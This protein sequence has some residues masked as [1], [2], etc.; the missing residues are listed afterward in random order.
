[1]S[2]WELKIAPERKNR[3]P[4]NGRFVKGC[5][6]YNKGRKWDKWMSKRGQKK[7]LKNLELSR[8]LYKRPPHA[9]RKKRKVIAV[10]DHGKFICFNSISEVGIW[11]RGTKGNVR[12]C[13][14]LNSQRKTLKNVKG[15]MTD[16]VN[17]D[18]KYKG[19]RFYFEDDSIWLDK[20]KK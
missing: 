16:R 13:C 18:H 5:T 12:R 4:V 15:E 3:N 17:T 10:N 14:K 7:A 8:K 19:V 2:S 1:M 11:I 6:S 20:V 9:G